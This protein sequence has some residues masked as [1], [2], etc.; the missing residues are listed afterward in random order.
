MGPAWLIR[1]GVLSWVNN[2][3]PPLG[4]QMKGRTV[5]HC[6]SPG[7][8]NAPQVELEARR[9]HFPHPPLLVS[10]LENGATSLVVGTEPLEGALYVSRMNDILWSRKRFKTG[11]SSIMEDAE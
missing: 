10:H 5:S 3:Y 7:D 2:S 1:E 6:E 8:L 11:I 4:L 9:G